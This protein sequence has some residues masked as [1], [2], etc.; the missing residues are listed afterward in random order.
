MIFFTVILRPLL[1]CISPHVST[2]RARLF[3]RPTTALYHELGNS[4]RGHHPGQGKSCL[5]A[6][7][8]S[9]I[10]SVADLIPKITAAF[11][12][13]TLEIYNDSHLHA[14]HKP[15]QGSTSSETHFR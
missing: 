1:A 11:D 14:H 12:P 6:V 4:C 10:R 7:V 8:V 2:I 3:E 13:Q 15:M 9:V 5:F